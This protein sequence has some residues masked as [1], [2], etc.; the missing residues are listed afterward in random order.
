MDL[1]DL[2]SRASDHLSVGRAFGTAYERNGALIIPVAFVAGGGGGGGTQPTT[3][4]TDSAPVDSD[5]VEDFDDDDDDD[6]DDDATTDSPTR[7]TSVVGSGGG[8]GGAVM[9]LGVYVVKDDRVRWVPAIN[10]TAVLVAA[11]GLIGVLAR[12]AGGRHRH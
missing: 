10:G 4:H 2:L 8:F 6:D 1:K 7:A 11:L 3:L 12:G 5:E 9:P